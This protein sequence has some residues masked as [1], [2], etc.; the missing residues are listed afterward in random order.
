MCRHEI[1]TKQSRFSLVSPRDLVELVSVDLERAAH[2][3]RVVVEHAGEVLGST[4]VKEVT[5]ALHLQVIKYVG[6]YSRDL[7]D[8]TTE[9][10]TILATRHKGE[11]LI[12]TQ[13]DLY[14]TP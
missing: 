11:G 13:Y 7:N 12:H 3:P 8:R 2:E 4:A 6:A 9:Y 10:R 14:G 1:I 5:L